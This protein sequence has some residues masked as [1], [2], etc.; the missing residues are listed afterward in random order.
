MPVAA[1][2]RR[3]VCLALPDETLQ[4]AAERME[5][6]G[7]GLLVVVDGGRP[8]GVLTDRDVA[9]QLLS[10]PAQRVSDAMTR[11]PRTVPGDA[12]LAEAIALMSRHGVRRLPVVDPDGHSVA[13]IA[14]DDLVQL[15]ADEVSGLA[16]VAAAQLSARVQA[17]PAS[18]TREAKRQVDHYLRPV[19]SLPLDADVSAVLDRMRHA[20]V[21]AVVLVDEAG[22]ARGIVTDRDIAVRVVARGIAASGTPVSS[23]MSVPV[24]TCDASQPLEEVVDRMRAAGVRRIPV[25]RDGQLAGIVTYDDLLAAVGDELAALGRV[26]KRQLQRGHRRER[27]EEARRELRHGLAQAATG[28]R[29]LAGEGAKALRRGSSALRARYGPRGR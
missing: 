17:E 21:G 10:G 15:V 24:V 9:L 5:K 1:Y 8:V 22:S 16:A 20:V 13:V 23:V 12:P 2:A 18:G 25:L 3:S 6:E 26:A 7:M 27:R 19:V 11:H 14:S 29:A 28:L 4:L